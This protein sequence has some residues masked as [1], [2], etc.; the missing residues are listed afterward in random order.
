M[1]GCFYSSIVG[2]KR[3]II[4]IFSLINE[5]ITSVTCYRTL[6]DPVHELKTQDNP[7]SV[8]IQ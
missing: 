1:L 3:I 4:I 8:A 6:Q 2:C 7:V 5:Q